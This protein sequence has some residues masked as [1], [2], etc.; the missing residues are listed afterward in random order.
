MLEAMT[1]KGAHEPFLD[2]FVPMLER[3][4][5]EEARLARRS[6]ETTLTTLSG[7]DRT[8]AEW[9]S[10]AALARL[11]DAGQVGLLYALTE[12]GGERYAI[13]ARLYARHFLA[14]EPY[15]EDALEAA[16]VWWPLAEG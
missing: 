7:M 1:K 2:E 10:K 14:G 13:L 3:A 15:P 5:T 16:R 6:L 4:G 11:A 8:R 9:H 12:V